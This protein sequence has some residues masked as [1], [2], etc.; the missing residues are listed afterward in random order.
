[1]SIV[2]CWDASKYRSCSPSSFHTWQFWADAGLLLLY[3]VVALL[4]LVA[5]AAL[6]KRYREAN[7]LTPQQQTVRQ[8][9]ARQQESIRSEAA[10]LNAAQ[11]RRNAVA[12]ER[13]RLRGSRWW[14]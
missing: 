1:V 2:P 10:R 3:L 12:R 6:H 9:R 13:R 11:D 8:A 7:P 4:L 14:W 5:M